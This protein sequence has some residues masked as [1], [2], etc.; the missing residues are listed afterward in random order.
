MIQINYLLK[1][2][3]IKIKHNKQWRP[4]YCASEGVI[5]PQYT[6]GEE[7][8][9]CYAIGTPVQL[10][11]T[12]EHLTIENPILSKLRKKFKQAKIEVKERAFHMHGVAYVS[13]TNA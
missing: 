7:R 11:K 13:I 3:S 2:D 1:Q 4:T 5:L 9:F 10:V 8:P 12:T 6:E